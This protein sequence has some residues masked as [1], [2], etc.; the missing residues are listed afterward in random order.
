MFDANEIAR[1]TIN[2]VES[3]LREILHELYFGGATIQPHLPTIPI[4]QS[5]LKDQITLLVN[6]ANGDY[7]EE[8]GIVAETIQSICETLFV[9]PAGA[10]S[11][12]IPEGFWKTPLG[13]VVMRCQL[14]LHHDELLTISEAAQLLRGSTD[15]ADLMF[16]R[17]AIDSGKLTAYTDPGEP[18]PTR[19]TRLSRAEVEALK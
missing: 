3:K 6:I 8:P 16:I 13:Q 19:A 7:A 2:Q 11:Y 15:K 4:Q 9:A 14:W 10:Y 17:R 18:N 12:E 5:P 1:S